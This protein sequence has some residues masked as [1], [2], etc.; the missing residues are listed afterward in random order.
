MTNRQINHPSCLGFLNHKLCK[1]MFRATLRCAFTMSASVTAAAPFS[2]AVVRAMRKLCVGTF[3][4]RKI[5]ENLRDSRYPEALAD[6]SWDNT[7]CRYFINQLFEAIFTNS[8]TPRSSLRPIT[9]PNELCP[10][11]RG[12][13]KSRGRRSH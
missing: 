12:P 8:S 1:L 13:H 5:W 11:N 6:K 4:N 7:G 9:T 10:S 2:R 3:E